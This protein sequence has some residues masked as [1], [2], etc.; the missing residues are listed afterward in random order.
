MRPA[1]RSFSRSEGTVAIRVT[2]GA[3]EAS[4]GSSKRFWARTSV[5]PWARVPKISKT[6]TSKEAEVLASVPAK[7]RAG[8]V[9][10]HQE[11]KATA[12]AWGTATPFGL[13]VEPEV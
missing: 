6:E 7:S 11:R 9:A 5:P 8:K 1:A 2:G 3:A 4:A 12:L 13:P 10:R